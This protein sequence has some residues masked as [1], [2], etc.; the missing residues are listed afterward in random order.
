M[1]DQILETPDTSL[2]SSMGERHP[3][4]VATVV[5]FHHEAPNTVTYAYYVR[6]VAEGHLETY[7]MRGRLLES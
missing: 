4:K 5:R 2:I 1:P 7:E 3:Y 6:A